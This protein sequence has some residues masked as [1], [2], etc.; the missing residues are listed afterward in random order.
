MRGR[1]RSYQKRIFFLQ[2]RNLKKLWSFHKLR[3]REW[4]QP[5]KQNHLE[6]AEKE[7]EKLRDLCRMR[8]KMWELL[9]ICAGKGGH[10]Y[11]KLATWL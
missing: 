6:K 4:R 11:G 10:M 7:Q 1:F 3:S 8:G 9:Q 5:L 2:R